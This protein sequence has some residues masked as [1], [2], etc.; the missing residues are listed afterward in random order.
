[1]SLSYR[2]QNVRTTYGDTQAQNTIRWA[3]KRRGWRKPN[4]QTEFQPLGF[5]FVVFCT[6]SLKA[7]RTRRPVVFVFITSAPM[8]HCCRPCTTLPLTRKRQKGMA[9]NNQ[10]QS[11]PH[12]THKP[13]LHQKS[14][15]TQTTTMTTTTAIL[16]HSA[17]WCLFRESRGPLTGGSLPA[18]WFQRYERNP[19]LGS[20]DN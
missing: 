4:G 14:K 12:T 17:A 18:T 13:P 16:R 15:H 20:R 3:W 7:L 1:V 6:N 2:H 5:P 9:A 8:L 10:T 19:L 11:R